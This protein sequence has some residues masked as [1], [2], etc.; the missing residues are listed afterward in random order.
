MKGRIGKAVTS[1]T[2][3][4]TWTKLCGQRKLPNKAILKKLQEVSTWV[5]IVHCV[6]S[7]GRDPSETKV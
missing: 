4:T 7:E 2:N 6:Q 1:G 5:P 3:F